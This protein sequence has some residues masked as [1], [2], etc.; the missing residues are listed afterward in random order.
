MVSDGVATSATTAVICVNRD[1]EAVDDR[2]EVREGDTLV[3][4][5]PGLLVNDV[6]ADGYEVTVC[7]RDVV[8]LTVDGGPVYEPSTGLIGED[9]F[10]YV[11]LD[12][13]IGVAMASTLTVTSRNA[14]PVTRWDTYETYVNAEFKVSAAEGVAAN[15]SDPDGPDG[16]DK[17][18][19][20][21]TVLVEPEHRTLA[22]LNEDGSF[23]SAPNDGSLE[24]TSRTHFRTAHR[25]TSKVK[26]PQMTP[27]LKVLASRVAMWI[28]CGCDGGPAA[29]GAIGDEA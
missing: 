16:P 28:L 10:D 18:L 20:V 23:A 27:L 17:V 29:I 19:S 14:P 3:A 6:D 13:A 5:A 7:G 1:P 25:T 9:A 12:K 8:V 22:Y 2:Y 11:V 21:T 4:T 26:T 15:D 24:L